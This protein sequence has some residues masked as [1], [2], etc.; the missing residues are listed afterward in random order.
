MIASTTRYSSKRQAI[1]DAICATNCH[2]SAEWVYKT[3]KPSIADLSLGTVYRNLQFLK[4]QNQIVS[5]G[6]FHGQEHFDGNIAPHCHFVCE[7]CGEIFDLDLPD[8][9]SVQLE[10]AVEEKRFSLRRCDVTL[11]G[12][13]DTCNLKG[14]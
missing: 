14:E 1:L 11:H 5:V 6:V 13:C 8:F 3:L 10:A 7:S 4:E 12:V 9:G 2:P